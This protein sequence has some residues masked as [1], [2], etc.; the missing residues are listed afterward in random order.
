MASKKADA[1]T[2]RDQL[3]E[4]QI[5]GG[6]YWGIQTARARESA[7]ATGVKPHPKL[8]DGIALIKRSCASAN[9]ES[10]RLDHQKARAIMQTCDEIL[11]GQW[12]DQFVVELL[13]SGAGTAFNINTNEVIANRAN[14]LLGGSI[15]SYDMVHPIHHVNLGQSTNDAFPSSMRIAVLMSARELEPVMLDLERLLRRKSL[16]FERVVKVG[17]THLQD[18]VPMTLGQEFN[19]YGS[20]IERGLRRLKESMSALFELNIGATHIGTGLGTDQNF[21]VHVVE[22]LSA[23]TG[24]RFRQADDFFR[25]SQSMSDFVE[26][27]SSLKELAID[28]CKIGADLRLL[29]S[30][31]V[32][33]LNEIKLPR[34]LVEP[35]PLL[36]GVLPERSNPTMAES[37]C[38]VSYQIMGNDTVVTLG[39]QSGQL[40]S[41]VMTPLIIQNILSSID[42]LKAIIPPFN[43]RFLAGITANEERSR[44]LV[45][46]SGFLL[47]ALSAQLGAKTASQIF[48]EAQERRADP[49][50]IA[51]EGGHISQEDLD[52]LMSARQLNA[53]AEKLSEYLSGATKDSTS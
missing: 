38:M 33:G 27:S 52:R 16:E 15:G 35:S 7:F 39:A 20:S 24:L 36:P 9:L 48:D 47:A 29:A 2:E 14:E 26:F 23:V 41:N 6:A 12:R 1:R 21:V 8:I 43:Q 37:L 11:G 49:K 30:G 13:H 28:L 31:P 17:R 45:E 22:K 44:Q 53:F 42:L 25:I 51:V 46:Q 18:S 50:R 3:G 34:S 40:E 19:A 4:A 5:P 32:G 10:K